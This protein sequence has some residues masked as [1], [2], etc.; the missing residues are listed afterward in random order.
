M[1]NTFD[2]KRFGLLVKKDFAESWKKY[3]M[4]VLLMFGVTSILFIWISINY[5]E[6]VR[7]AAGGDYYRSFGYLSENLFIAGMILLL[8][9]GC[10]SASWLM[11]SIRDKTRRISYLTNPSSS[12]EKYI[13]RWGVQVVLFLVVYLAIFFVADFI[14]WLVCTIRYPE[15]DVRSVDMSALLDCNKEYGRA[16]FN[17]WKQFFMAVSMYFFIQSLFILG[18]AF[19]QKNSFIKTFCAGFIIFLVYITLC[20]GFIFALFDEGMRDFSRVFESVIIR[21]NENRF[22]YLLI[23]G[24]SL[25]TVVNWVLSYFRFK[26]TEITKRI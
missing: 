22:I 4:A 18:S 13:I 7:R 20:G 12:F 9:Y 16:I 26:E 14:Q 19:W 21:G 11:D 5:Y 25:F 10:L 1:N 6:D 3:L 8:V 24:L 15:L 23:G 2:I 17:D